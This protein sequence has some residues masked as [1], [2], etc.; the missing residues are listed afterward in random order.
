MI[1]YWQASQA[2]LSAG[3]I[4]QTK[5]DLMDWTGA[6]AA[7]FGPAGC[8]VRAATAA[9]IWAKRAATSVVAVLVAVDDWFWLDMVTP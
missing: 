6:L 2:A 9:L 3:S 8:W 1:F 5:A 4:G 7:G